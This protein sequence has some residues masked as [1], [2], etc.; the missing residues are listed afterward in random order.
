M[1]RADTVMGAAQPCLEVG[2]HEVNDRQECLGNLHVAAFRDG[3]M[4]IAALTQLHVTAPVVGDD[5][6]AG[7]NG[8][9]DEPPHQLGAPLWR[10]GK[11]NAPCVPPGPALIPAPLHLARTDFTGAS[12]KGAAMS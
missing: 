4:A 9:L 10:T 8:A 7:C 11:P 2:E 1:L 6:G 12:G 3:R 5:G